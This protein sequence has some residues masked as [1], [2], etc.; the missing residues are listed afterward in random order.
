MD[1]K[2]LINK[3]KTYVSVD[4]YRQLAERYAL[5]AFILVTVVV[6]LFTTLTISYS[7]FS[8]NA[9]IQT[10]DQIFKPIIKQLLDAGVDTG[11]INKM[12]LEPS[13]Q[14]N[15]K[16]VKINVTGMFKKTDYSHFYN[17]NSVAKTKEFIGNNYSQLEKAEGLFS[18]PKEVIASILWIETKHGNFLGN[19]NIASVFFSTALCN[20]KEYIELN[21]Q[22]IRENPDIKPEQYFEFDLK[23]EQRAE[24]KANWAIKE[25]IALEKMDKVSTTPVQN[26]NGSW[27]GAFGCSQFLPSSYIS[28]G[29]DGNGDGR[30]NL[31]EMDDAIFSVANYLKA[32]GWGNDYSQ[33]KAAVFHYN[34]SNDYV[35]AVLTLASLAKVG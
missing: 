15:E 27:A 12:L 1:K 14:F 5:I 31:F 20:Q 18:V 21:K 9:Y 24:K 34:N 32:N 10:K 19:N 35:N 30:V 8:Q 3:M 6:L 7:S 26:I 22:S 29:V 16:F 4:R 25:I 2:N 33:Q 17:S 28:W 11:F 13:V 23:I